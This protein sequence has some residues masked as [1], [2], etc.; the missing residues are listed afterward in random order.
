M[1]RHKVESSTVRRRRLIELIENF[2]DEMVKPCSTCARHG[3]RCKVH[4]RSGKC[5]ECLRRN[6]RCDIRVT[7]SEFDRLVEEKKKLRCQIKEAFEAQE[8]AREELRIAHAREMRL[9]Q[10][11]DLLDHRAAEAISVE[12]R[13]IEEQEAEERGE[14]LE[15]VAEHGFSLSPMTWGALDGLDDD[16]W[17]LP[18][19][20]E[21]L[22][23]SSNVPCSQA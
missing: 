20:P 18:G 14:I 16:F 17:E 12:E 7:K 2:G 9:R 6:Q 5:S 23:S 19:I 13:G 1:P 3:R 15:S 8:K 22:A 4:I 10:Q 11:M 21:A